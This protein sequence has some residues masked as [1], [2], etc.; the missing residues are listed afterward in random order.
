MECDEA[1]VVIKDQNGPE[2][3]D[4]HIKVITELQL[5]NI[6]IDAA[7]G[8]KANTSAL[9]LTGY[10]SGHGLEAIKGATG[11]DINGVIREM[12]LADGTAQA[13]ANTTIQL[14]SGSSA[15]NDIYN[16]NLIFI[17]SGTGLGQSRLITDYVG[18]TTTATVDTAWA[19][20][21]GASSVYVIA[22]GPRTWYQS[23]GAELTTT[24]TFASTYGKLLQALFQWAF[25]KR[26]QTATKQQFYKVDDSTALM[27]ATVSD[28]ATT[29]TT[30]RIADV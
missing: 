11:Q 13:G 6:D 21:P 2:F 16:G 8:T 29:Q 7:S 14:A 10:G 24:P 28:D 18:S 20:N 19:V 12:V 15:T 27:E 1:D 26:T 17:V 30:G 5:G 22:P 4:A 3:R 9:K 23:P 25:Y